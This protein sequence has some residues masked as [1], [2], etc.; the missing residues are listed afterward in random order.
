MAETYQFV[1]GEV[2]AI[3]RAIALAETVMK[4]LDYAHIERK[5]FD[6]DIDNIGIRIRIPHDGHLDEERKSL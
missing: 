4:D 5:D 1:W 3:K 6:L 2:P